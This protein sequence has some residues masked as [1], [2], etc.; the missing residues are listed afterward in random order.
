MEYTEPQRQAISHDVGNLQLIA[1]AGSG[2]TEVVSRRI[3]A[4]L[5]KGI[6]PQS[7]IAFT[8]TEKAAAELKDRIASHVTQDLGEE[9][10]KKL[11]DLFAGTIHGFCFRLLQEQ[12]ERFNNFDALT[13][14]TEVALLRRFYTRLKISSI[15][16]PET[17]GEDISHSKGIRLFLE[18]SEVVYNEL[19]QPKS[20]KSEAGNFIDALDRY[21][22]LLAEM[23]LISFSQMIAWATRLVEEDPAVRRYLSD[24]VRHV[25]V[26]EY[27]DINPAQERLIRLIHDLGAQVCVVG[28]DDQSIYQWRGADILNILTFAK[29]YPKVSVISLDRN[30]RST[31]GIVEVANSVAGGIPDRLPKRMIPHVRKE[32][33]DT[34]LIECTTEYDEAKFVVS[35][36]KLFREQGYEWRDIAVLLRSV[37]TSAGPILELLREN[38]IPYSVAGKVGLFRRPEIRFLG[39]L[40]ARWTGNGW[41]ENQFGQTVQVTDHSLV[42]DLSLLFPRDLKSAPRKLASLMEIG[43]KAVESDRPDLVGVYQDVL[44]TL[45]FT[46]LDVGK[47]EDKPL[48]DSFGKF[49]QL[50]TDFEHMNRRAAPFEPAE[51]G[52]GGQKSTPT[53]IY[54][55]SG[56]RF[57]TS[58]HWFIISHA[59]SGYEEGS[60]DDFMDFN[61]VNVMTIHQAKGLEF[62]VVFLPSLVARRFPS[63]KMGQL[64]DWVIPVT[65]F[66][67]KRYEGRLEDERRLFYVAV[68]RAKRALVLSRFSKY[69]SGRSTGATPFLVELIR[70]EKLERYESLGKIIHRSAARKPRLQPPLLT[71]FSDLSLY[72]QCPYKYRLRLVHGFQPPLAPE[73]GYGKSLHHIITCLARNVRKGGRADGKAVDELLATQF[74]LP[75]AG[76]AAREMMVKAAR[77]SLVGYVESYG[78]ELKRVVESESRFEVPMEKAILRGKIDL[79]LH[80]GNNGD[81]DGIEVVEFKT[82][83][84][85]PDGGTTDSYADSQISLYAVAAEMKGNRVDT[86]SVHD[87]HANHRHDVLINEASRG[88][89]VRRM[90][91]LVDGIRSCCFSP[92]AGNHCKQCDYKS[93]CRYL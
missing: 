88:K 28:D 70:A 45:G 41:K 80:S 26:D 33:P 18:N 81:G 48:F 64:K 20:L 8:F 42:Q 24:T 5:K 22:R 92:Q 39:R 44:S 77:R 90:N 63:S 62:P 65:M 37:S 34:C 68:T 53:A 69:P 12:S 3:S 61:A 83:V 27:Q 74:Y 1:C 38:G 49:S 6:P 87:L 40:I 10:R 78:S 7:I 2:K 67:R 25:V 89:I 93:I 23:R 30:Y 16:A 86:A 91:T 76:K 36:I 84:A 47:E 15:C 51:S 4:L 58:L 9:Y 31:P 85:N 75:L 11:G 46:K 79:V 52:E 43:K 54:R 59:A 32:G 14:H 19:I 50:L 72:E 56:I 82:K 17:N 29:R 60:S 13:E 35:G 21:E 57:W 73:L 66:D 55:A 71:S